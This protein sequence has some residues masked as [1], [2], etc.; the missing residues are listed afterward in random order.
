MIESVKS[1]A[2]EIRFDGMPVFNPSELQLE[3]VWYQTHRALNASATKITGSRLL[4]GRDRYTKTIDIDRVFTEIGIAAKDPKLLELNHRPYVTFNTGTPGTQNSIFLC[5]LD[6]QPFKPREVTIHGRKKT[7]KNI[8]FYRHE[9][10]LHAL[11]QPF[12]CDAVEVDEH[13]GNLHLAAYH[14]KK[15]KRSL[16]KAIFGRLARIERSFGS[17]LCTFSGRH[18]VTLNYKLYFLKRRVYVP[19]I[20]EIVT[21]ENK[22]TWISR[23]RFLIHG[24]ESVLGS[25]VKFNRN[26]L[27]CMYS[28]GLMVDEDNFIIFYGLN[29]RAGFKAKVK[30][31]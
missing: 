16:V 25:K 9:G 20:F 8:V 19:R 15:K 6:E 2:S 31:K 27:G 11:Y 4:V 30:R 17:Q 29:D 26:I 14:S 28:S 22:V 13:C 24:L 12:Q 5:A 7:E 23:S 3:G 1:S 10:K 21:L 18:F